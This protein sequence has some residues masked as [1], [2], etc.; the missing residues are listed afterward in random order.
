MEALQEIK[1]GGNPLTELPF[2]LKAKAPVKKQIL[3]FI[4]ESPDII[5]STDIPIAPPIMIK[6]VIREPFIIFGVSLAELMKQEYKLFPDI[7]VPRILRYATDFIYLHAI[8]NEGIFRLAGE[9]VRCQELREEIDHKTDIDFLD[10]ENPHN[11]S[12]IL[13]TWI[14]ELPEPMLLFKNFEKLLELVDQEDEEIIS[15]L[16]EIIEDL[17]K[18]NYY[19]AKELFRLMYLVSLS[20]EVNLM[21]A[22]NI[23][24][25]IGPNMLF[26]PPAIASDPFSILTKTNQIN[27]ILTYGVTNYDKIFET[28]ENIFD[29]YSEFSEDE[30]PQVCFFFFF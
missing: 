15:K 10:S 16:K 28:K 7:P 8:S 21:G 5:G 20:K 22:S 6:E 29:V 27:D 11:V 4:S 26:A 2:K 17:P 9:N 25:V 14:R 12:S 30:V 13:K 24:K 18:E 3:T 23:T 1:V 19:C